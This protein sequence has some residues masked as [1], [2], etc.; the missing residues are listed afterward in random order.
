MHGLP[1]KDKAEFLHHPDYKPIVE[2]MYQERM[3]NKSK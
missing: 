2:Q 1:F 3:E